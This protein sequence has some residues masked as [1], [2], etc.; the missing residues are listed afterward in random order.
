LN[1]PETWIQG[2]ARNTLLLLERNNA[3]KKQMDSFL[4][5]TLLGW[6]TSSSSSSSSTTADDGVTI[7]PAVMRA[8]RRVDVT[9]RN[10]MWHVHCALA[11]NK[12]TMEYIVD[13]LRRH[14]YTVSQLVIVSFY[15]L[16]DA[17]GSLTV[18]KD[19]LADGTTTNLVTFHIQSNGINP[20]STGHLLSAL[21]HPQ[22]SS[23]TKL[24][25]SHV[26]LNGA[27]LQQLLEKTCTLRQLE[28]AFVNLAVDGGIR[29]LA[30]GLLANHATNRQKNQHLDS[31]SSSSSSSSLT[32]LAIRN[33]ILGGEKKEDRHP[34]DVIVDA[35]IAVSTTT[36]TTTTA[37]AMNGDHGNQ[38]RRGGLESLH[39]ADNEITT[40]ATAT[41]MNGDHDN[42][43]RRGGL[44][45]LHLADNEITTTTTTTTTTA[46]NNHFVSATIRLLEQSRLK[47]L[48]LG[49]Y[50]CSMLLLHHHHVHLLCRTLTRKNASSSWLRVLDLSACHE[51][52]DVTCAMLIHTLESNETLQTLMLGSISNHNYH[53]QSSQQPAANEENNNRSNDINNNNN[54]AAI[55]SVRHHHHRHHHRHHHPYPQS[56][57]QLIASLPNMK[58]LRR[59]HL[60]WNVLLS[61]CSSTCAAT[62]S[63]D[64]HTDP[65]T[66]TAKSEQPEQQPD[67]ITTTVSALYRN[68]SLEQLYHGNAN[69]DTTK[70]NNKNAARVMEAM[71][72][73]QELNLLKSLF[74][75]EQQQP[76]T[77]AVVGSSSSGRCRSGMQTRDFATRMIPPGLWLAVLHTAGTKWQNA[78]AVYKIIRQ[79]T[80]HDGSLLVVLHSNYYHHRH[81]PRP[82]AAVP[83]QQ[84]QKETAAKSVTST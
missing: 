36:T 15:M 12:A 79:A 31:S 30:A 48:V 17:N 4:A 42:R 20:M 55:M 18:L 35:I 5:S 2:S 19:Y 83:V 51:I 9:K 74:S 76:P 64:N 67:I 65:T 1:G 71:K 60:P 23:I 63:S 73:N 39:L 16:P 41:A 21:Y 27:C 82:V 53:I 29:G 8:V 6:L 14:P 75:Q 57:R 33:C 72:R 78:T 40:T 10:Q 62:V 11:P 54:N 47:T 28:L 69:I 66:A 68:T 43:G 22:E 56:S 3:K 38:G 26:G 45:S 50:E 13:F 61:S 24:V 37:T 46:S 58:G 80:F 59:L 52:P 81:Q 34:L 44:E 49:E 7:D 84:V 32:H 25:L 77:R 70:N